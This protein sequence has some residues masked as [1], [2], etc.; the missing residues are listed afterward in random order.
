MKHSRTHTREIAYTALMVYACLYDAW[1]FWHT[2]I[3]WF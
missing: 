3:C 2:C 1:G